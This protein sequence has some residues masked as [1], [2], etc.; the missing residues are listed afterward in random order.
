MSVT[1]QIPVYV[2]FDASSNP[3]GINLFQAEDV[4]AVNNGGTGTSSLAD[5]G[6]A[7][8]ATDVVT[9]KMYAIEFSGTAYLGDR[10]LV[11]SVSSTAASS[12]AFVGASVSATTASSINM[13]AT[14]VSATNVSAVSLI[15]GEA[16]APYPMPIP[17]PWAWTMV[18]VAGTAESDE[19][20]IGV[21]AT[22]STQ[23]SS[24]D[25]IEWDTDEERFDVKATGTYELTLNAV[26]SVAST[27]VV[28]LK[29]YSSAP[30]DAKLT[31]TTTV[32]SSIDPQS[33]TLTM[34]TVI[35]NGS[36]A[37]ATTTDDAST[38]V[39]VEPGTTL[40]LKRLK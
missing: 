24:T 28:T 35:S 26:L 21:G 3:S 15:V 25:E 33:V 8:S 10:V 16:G 37:F 6:T 32:H 12:L 22:T 4:F 19:Q 27:T 39:T 23:Q 18:T 11:T 38:D 1:E 2:G 20:N 34:V 17:A 7:L 36:Y 31:A 14:G 40:M 29:M 9:S 13:A 5:F 30:G